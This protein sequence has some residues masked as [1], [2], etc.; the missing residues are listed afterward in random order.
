MIVSVWKPIY[1]KGKIKHYD[2]VD[3]EHL[4]D[5]KGKTA[6]KVIWT[7]DSENCKTQ[8]KKHSI[9]ACHLTKTNMNYHKQICR[10]CQ[11]SGVNNGRYG[12][13]RKWDDFF[14]EK[15]LSDMKRI[16][17][18]KWKGDKNPSVFDEVK[19]KKGQ[20]IIN[21]D[22]IEKMVREKNFKL[23]EILNLKGKK[24]EFVIQCPKNHTSV[25]RYVN[26][27]RKEKKFL[28]QKCF[29][30]SIGIRP[31]EIEEYKVYANTV[32]LITLK[33]Y[34]KYKNTINPNGLNLKKGE[35][36]LDHR[37]SIFEGFKNNVPIEII[38]SKENLEVI[39]EKENLIKGIKCSITLNELNEMTRYLYE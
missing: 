11:C 6:Y 16:Y 37:Y 35:Y 24:S 30:E 1:N 20:T 5:P 26:F 7:C 27:I 14:D 29:Y 10:P 19:I 3:K 39:S 31:Y 12:D 23:V 13:R 28:C 8:N 34:R 32:R 33:T 15:K 9:S 25:K 22:Y 18:Q 17:S 4:L 21:E 36:N 2:L 38:C